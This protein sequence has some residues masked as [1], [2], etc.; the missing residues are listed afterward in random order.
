MF[1]RVIQK[2]NVHRSDYLRALLSDTMPGDI[3]IIVSNDGTYKNLKNPAAVH[4]GI[5]EFASTAFTK[6]RSYTVPYRYNI[7]RVGG[8]ARRLS[9]IHP[10]AQLE[11]AAFYRDSGQLICYYARRSEA[12]L[13]APHKTASLFFVR[14]SS[15]GKN[16]FK[17]ADIDTVSLENSVANPAS[18]FAYRGYSRAYQFF[19]STDY[20]RLEK[21]YSAAI[22]TD[23]SKCF[24]S[25][26]THTLYWAVV[27]TLAGK[28]NTR[29][30]TFS[31]R[32]DHLMQSM[33]FNETN[34]I[35][36]GAEVSR[37]FAEIILGEVDRRVIGKLAAAD[38][39]LKYRSEYEFFRY[40]DD[41]YIFAQSSQIAERVLW[42]ISSELSNFNLH[43]GAEKTAP[44]ARPFITSKS[45]II[46][47]ANINIALFCEK[48]LKGGERDDRR[49][50]YPL[51]IWRGPSLLRGF[52]EGVKAACFDHA[53]GYQSSSDYVISALSE[54]ISTLTNSY[55]VA[56]SSGKAEL[57]HYVP[58]LL[59]LLEAS[60]FF[61]SVNPTVS[62]SHKLSR[63][64]VLAARFTRDHVPDRH[65][66]LMEHVMR[67][68]NQVL[69][70]LRSS[71]SHQDT[72]CVPLEILNILLAMA[73]LDSSDQNA[74]TTIAECCGDI[75]K[76]GYFE[77]VTYLYCIKDRPEHA[78]LRTALFKRGRELIAN[79]LGI[80]VDSESAHL[81]LDLLSCP[82][83]ERSR[84]AS[85]FN[86]IRKSV[87]LAV[88]PTADALAAVVACESTPWFVNWKETDLLRLIRKKEL[89]AVY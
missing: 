34:G 10:A 56:L 84:R 55:V 47:D 64:V 71:S 33:N 19:S 3:P 22:M 69:H 11:V 80:Q 88:L 78:K 60:F 45:R 27:N 49:F 6:S 13:R 18:Y 77:I 63:S 50:L 83:L 73:D 52:L 61:Y 75:R 53:T 70:S 5:A 2:G 44:L 81:A 48:F 38:S 40:V 39:P 14:G 89:S 17:A 74:R 1:K 51:R 85:F 57:E 23:I 46:R 65:Q 26:Y 41:Y 7:L 54:R 59:L 25:I 82:F 31:N 43:L 4:S 24:S 30:D 15:S 12:T 32:F 86:N 29:A 42:S 72:D 37:I 16:T 79:N 67:W 36:V 35:C 20:I 9:L 8:G 28:E 21:K 87:G 76:A 68:T 62:S 58:A 66:M